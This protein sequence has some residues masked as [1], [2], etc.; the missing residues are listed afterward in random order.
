MAHVS[1][2]DLQLA[3]R[4]LVHQSFSHGGDLVRHAR[5]LLT[6]PALQVL[7]A[8]PEAGAADLMSAM[9]SVAHLYSPDAEQ[10]RV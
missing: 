1:Q 7:C 9:P 2:V 6:P 3:V 10:Y 8:A 4:I 5:P